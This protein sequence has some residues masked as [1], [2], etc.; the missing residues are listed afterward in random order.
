M[1]SPTILTDERLAWAR[2]GKVGEIVDALSK[3]GFHVKLWFSRAIDVSHPEDFEGGTLIRISRHSG[4]GRLYLRLWKS[5][6]ALEQRALDLVYGEGVVNWGSLDEHRGFFGCV[7]LPLD[8]S[9]TWKVRDETEQG[10]PT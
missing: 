5:N 3:A 8:L 9:T 4:E 2:E 10:K 6:E 7:M 1:I